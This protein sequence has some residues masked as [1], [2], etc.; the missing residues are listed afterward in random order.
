[1]KKDNQRYYIEDFIVK[2]LPIKTGYRIVSR[3]KKGTGGRESKRGTMSDRT[4][5]STVGRKV[6]R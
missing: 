2:S 4:E 5:G 1:M 3:V 6:T